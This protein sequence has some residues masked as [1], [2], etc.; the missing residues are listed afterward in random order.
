VIKISDDNENE[1]ILLL[2]SC[3]GKSIPKIA[4]SS[5]GKSFFKQL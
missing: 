5:A 3:H 2:C 4:A 1:A